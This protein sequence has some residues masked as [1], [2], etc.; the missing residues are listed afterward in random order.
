M[1]GAHLRV[2]HG[3]A[4]GLLQRA[5]GVALETG[6]VRQRSD[7][8]LGGSHHGWAQSRLCVQVEGISWRAV[9]ELELDPVSLIQQRSGCGILHQGQVVPGVVLL[10]NRF[11]E[12]HEKH[13]EGDDD[14]DHQC[15]TDQLFLVDHG[16]PRLHVRDKNATQAA[17]RA[18]ESR[19]A[20]AVEGTVS[21]HTHTAVLTLPPWIHTVAFI[22][23]VPTTAEFENAR[24]NKDK[25]RS[26]VS[27][28]SA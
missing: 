20:V 8:D 4:I 27:D 17:A 23:V 21:V 7:W 14:E 18:H 2:L 28:E 24:K 16:I 10:E 25:I 22:Y 5:P 19:A 3:T 12:S 1:E 11:P 9:Q 26:R 15:N 13:N 6:R